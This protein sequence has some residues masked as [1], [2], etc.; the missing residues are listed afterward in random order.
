MDLFTVTNKYN[1]F[2]FKSS[3]TVILIDIFRA[4]S[5]IV[6]AFANGTK[7]I[8]PCVEIEQVLNLKDKNSEI[9]TAGERNGEK[10][11]GFDLD[12]SPISFNSEFVRSKSIAISTT[13]CTKAIEIAKNSKKIIFASFLNID[14]VIK[15]ITRQK[16][17]I[18]RC[19]ILCAGNNEEE[20]EEDNLFA[21]ELIYR[22][23]E[24]LE[25]ALCN[26]SNK[27]LE[28]RVNTDITLYKLRNSTHAKR[29]ENLGKRNDI[30][31]SLIFNKFD[32][33]PIYANRSIKIK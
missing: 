28:S 33:V 2:D 31:F 12:N 8:I 17:E 22:L 19:V 15:Y 25:I 32:C 14:S 26:R 11:I 30:D 6:T 27:L 1:Q 20:S 13:N 24:N 18:D 10:I 23:K 9:L 29:L 21:S 3:D 7:E 16:F 5:T 4:S